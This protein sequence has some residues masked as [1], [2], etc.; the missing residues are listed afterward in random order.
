MKGNIRIEDALDYAKAYM[1]LK[2]ELKFQMKI[3]LPY[4]LFSQFLND[5]DNLIKILNLSVLEIILM[6]EYLEVL[7]GAYMS[8]KDYEN[9]E[10]I[11]QMILT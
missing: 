3:L 8:K 6:L 4:I 10:R 7:R 1:D 5:Y 9:A 11:Y 2:G